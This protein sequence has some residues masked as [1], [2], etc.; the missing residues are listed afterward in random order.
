[1]EDSD[2]ATNSGGFE[3]QLYS[4]PP[5]ERAFAM[6]P[7]FSRRNNL[8]RPIGPAS[9]GIGLS[10]LRVSPRPNSP[11]TFLLAALTTNNQR[12]GS[13]NRRFYTRVS[14]PAEWRALSKNGGSSERSREEAG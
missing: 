5:T 8:P 14:L 9:H 10:C 7:Q 6:A 12:R 2:A 1:M 3:T 11:Q 4:L 13:D